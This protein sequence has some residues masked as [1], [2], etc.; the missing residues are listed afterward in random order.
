MAGCAQVT[1]RLPLAASS[2]APHTASPGMAFVT[3][4][5]PRAWRGAILS[6]GRSLASVSPNSF[7]QPAVGSL[8][9]G[10]GSGASLLP[11]A[12]PSTWASRHR[13]GAG[14]WRNRALE[15]AVGSTAGTT[16]AGPASAG[17]AARVCWP[18]EWSNPARRTRRSDRGPESA[19][20][21]RRTQP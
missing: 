13:R 1:G 11:R 12:A 21:L 9:P 17:P 4:C 3:T 5:T 19:S 6:R 20:E 7:G 2:Q 15:R 8:L 10:P 18:R 16:L 14:R